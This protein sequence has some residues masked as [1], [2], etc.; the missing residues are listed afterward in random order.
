MEKSQ[1]FTALPG[2]GGI[3]IGLTAVVAAW[4]AS[5]QTE[6]AAWIM[7]WMIEALLAGSIALFSLAQKARRSGLSL[8][9]GPGRR[10]LLGMGPAV[11]TGVLMTV[12]LHGAG[13]FD[14]I[15]GAWLL[16]YG[17]AIIAAGTFS[18]PAVPLMGACFMVLGTVATLGPEAWFNECMALGFG[19]LHIGFGWLIA[20]KYGG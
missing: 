9:R 8:A 12:S 15:P 18:V 16:L 10:F 13:Q 20:R 2:R 7:V 3:A 5:Q 4:V 19:G 1:A 14:L 6:D 11:L 17:A